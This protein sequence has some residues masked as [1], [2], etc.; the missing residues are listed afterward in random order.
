[1]SREDRVYQR[2]LKEKRETE[3]MLFEWATL[4]LIMMFV[5]AVGIHF[6][7]L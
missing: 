2:R 5:T 1:M 6:G 4:I 3:Q 7:V